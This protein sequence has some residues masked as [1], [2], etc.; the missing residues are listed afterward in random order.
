MR[1]VILVLLIVMQLMFFLNFILNSDVLFGNIYIW[2]VMTLISLYIGYIS[3]N[4]EANLDE[5]M[6]THKLIS[7]SLFILSAVAMFTMLY[8]F[9]F[10][11][12]MVF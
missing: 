10:Q 6:F 7:W 2:I 12:Y 8:I 5:N 9:I 11:R 1:R 4:S 3:I